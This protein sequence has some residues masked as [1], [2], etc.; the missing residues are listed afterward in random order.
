MGFFLNMELGVE[1][2]TGSLEASAP[3]ALSVTQPLPVSYMCIGNVGYGPA[4]DPTNS[5]LQRNTKSFLQRRLRVRCSPSVSPLFLRKP[6]G[7]TRSSG[8]SAFSKRFVGT[9]LEPLHMWAAKG[10][11]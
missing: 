7:L 2:N 3:V 5:G 4:F 1:A 8:V 10:R 6:F 11:I 9:L